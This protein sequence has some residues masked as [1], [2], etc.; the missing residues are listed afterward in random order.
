MKERRKG[1][2][3]TGSNSNCLPTKLHEKLKVLMNLSKEKKKD[4]SLK[5]IQDKTEKQ[6]NLRKYEEKGK[7]PD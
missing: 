2:L 1:S 5:E 7:G 6:N 3:H 4:I